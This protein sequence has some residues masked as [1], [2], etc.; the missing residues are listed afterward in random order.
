MD[1]ALDA[2][3]VAAVWEEHPTWALLRSYNGRWVL[4]LF[5]RHLE[6]AD[7][8]VSA[9]WFHQKVA[10][11]L[12]AL[13]DDREPPAG[14][15]S[16][17]TSPIEYCRS[18]VDSRW[19]IRSRAG[20][21]EGRARYRLSQYA[22]QALRIVRELA[23]PDSAVSEARFASIAHAV[24]HLAAL[25]DPTAESQLERLDREIAALQARRD[26]IAREGAVAASPE[27]VARQVR[28]VLRLT[29]TLPED[30]RQL[31]AMVEQRHRE[32]ARAASSQHVGKGALVD[33]FLRDNDLLEQTPEGRAYRGFAAMLSSRELEA[34]R[35]D[36]DRVL[37][38]PAAATE[39]TERQRAQLETLITSLLAEE[40][41]VQETYVRWTSS[42]RRFLSRSGS[43][44]HARLL[45]LAA[46]A[47]D[48]GAAWAEGRPG[49]VLVDEDVLGI[50][51][52]DL[53]DVTQTQLWRDRGRPEVGVAI[54]ENDDPLPEHER[55]A[56]R[57]AVGTSTAAVRETIDAL[58]SRSET[59]TG[60]DV[61]AGTPAEFRRLG[62]A[63]S[64][65]ELAAEHGAVAEGVQ[66]VPLELAEST[67]E[68]TMPL[69][70]FGRDALETEAEDR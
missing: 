45:G 64:L 32:V 59:V 49:P 6:Y 16:S 28:E 40:Q 37:S 14:A 42:L 53:V 34:M 5:S 8:T 15:E 43:D 30:F 24:H 31:G 39:L 51:G 68:V 66:T 52:W 27:T 65:V 10:E 20:A 46:R 19:L 12:D 11:A 22:L 70:V 47:L 23:E 17:R 35:T 7:G 67:R 13:D 29:A 38:R 63:V 25:T 56:L 48:A 57:L 3:R 18:W 41:A 1:E 26:A 69:L 61:Y 58:L 60:A 50:G 2:G 36:I 4:P 62:L 21:G 55:E 44:R 54:A 33:R 9:D